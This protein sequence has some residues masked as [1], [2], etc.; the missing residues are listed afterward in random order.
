MTTDKGNAGPASAVLEV[1]PAGTIT[2]RPG[3]SLGKTAFPTTYTAPGTLITY[4]YVLTNTGN[5]TLTGPFTVA[6][7]KLGTFACGSAS[8][9][10]GPGQFVTCTNT[11]TTV[12]GDIGNYTASLPH[13]ANINTGPWLSFTN[14]TQDTKITGGGLDVPNGTYSCWCIQ[15]HV[16]LDL[17]NQPGMLYSTIGSTL[18][19]DVFGL[20][21]GKINYTLN[22]KIRGPYGTGSGATSSSEGC[23]TAIWVL[24][25]SR[26]PS[27]VWCHGGMINAANAQPTSPPWLM[28]FSPS[29]STRRHEDRPGTSGEHLRDRP[30]Q[31]V[32]KATGSGEGVRSVRCRWSSGGRPVRYAAISCT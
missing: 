23:A 6:D 14:S 31:S 30:A 1:K 21:W 7:D 12:N 3:L 11:Y 2:P 32:N 5:T 27:L 9:I 10:L 20:A 8:T 4:T 28:T 13:G 18:P 24:L 15:D 26:I 25:V 29:S 22:H 17:H 16:P 19:S